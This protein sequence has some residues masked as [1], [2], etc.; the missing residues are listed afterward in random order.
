M[1]KWECGWA[2]AVFS[3]D[4]VYLWVLAPSSGPRNSNGTP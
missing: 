1:L 3:A 4:R 2:V